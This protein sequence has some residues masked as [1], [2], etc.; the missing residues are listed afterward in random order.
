MY[1]RTGYL[2]QSAPITW[3][4]EQFSFLDAQFANFSF[5]TLLYKEEKEQKSVVTTIKLLCGWAMER[6]RS[7]LRFS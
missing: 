5:G 2:L 6:H 4:P 1:Q 7:T 3:T